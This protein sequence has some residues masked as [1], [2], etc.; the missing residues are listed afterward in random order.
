[1]IVPL[2]QSPVALALNFFSRKPAKT[3]CALRA[4]GGTSSEKSGCGLAIGAG[5]A[6][7]V[8]CF[9]EL[10]TPSRLPLVA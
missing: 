2:Q 9:D 5:Y 6:A 8:I 4:S 1:M 7:T 10:A 3:L